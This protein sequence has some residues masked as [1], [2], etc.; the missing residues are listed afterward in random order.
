MRRI[1][2]ILLALTGLLCL[3]P[4]VRCAADDAQTQQQDEPQTQQQNGKRRSKR[5]AADDRPRPGDSLGIPAKSG[6]GGVP[7]GIP[8]E[9]VIDERGDTVFVDSVEPAFVFPKGTRLPKNWRK[10]YRLVYNFAKVYPYVPVIS[11]VI[12]QTDSTIAA[13]Q[14]TRREKS[15]YISG[16]QKDILKDFAPAVRHMTTSQGKLLVRLVDREIGKTSYDIVK[17]YKNGF[18]AGFWQG[19]A[20]LFGQNLKSHYDPEGADKQT[21]ELVQLWERGEFE[22]LYRSIYF[23]ELPKT[24]IPS[25]YR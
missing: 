23:D 7:T 10:Y 19:V 14:M 3:C 8:M 20:R 25:K 2:A 5:S 18:T 13:E 22:E 15:A 1:A 12:A 11:A 16:I 24:Y 17:D 6:K 4:D 21:E 9:F